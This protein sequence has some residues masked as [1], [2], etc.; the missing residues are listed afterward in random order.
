MFATSTQ[1]SSYLYSRPTD[2]PN[3]GV[4][5]VLSSNCDKHLGGYFSWKLF[6]HEKECYSTIEKEYLAIRLADPLEIG[7][8]AILFCHLLSKGERRSQL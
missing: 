1:E 2:A 7:T 6:P 5:A 8:S 3:W 4:D